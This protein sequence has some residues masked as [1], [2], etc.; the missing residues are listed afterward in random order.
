[1]YYKVKGNK[2]NG[3]TCIKPSLHKYFHS[4]FDEILIQ[5]RLS[6]LTSRSGYSMDFM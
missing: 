3:S 6:I 1:V 5:I 2:L 4:V